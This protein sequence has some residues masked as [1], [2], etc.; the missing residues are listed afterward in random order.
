M[1]TR[2]YCFGNQYGAFDVVLRLFCSFVQ[3]SLRWRHSG[4]PPC[5]HRLG[6]VVLDWCRLTCMWPA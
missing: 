5:G 2:S 6:P 4:L 1:D 3:F